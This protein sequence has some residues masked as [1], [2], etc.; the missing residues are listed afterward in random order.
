MNI[1]HNV[2]IVYKMLLYDLL[3][4][5]ADS[6]IKWRNPCEITHHEQTLPQIICHEGIQLKSNLI[7][8][9]V[10]CLGSGPCCEGCKYLDDNG[11]TVKCLGC[12]LGLCSKASDRHPKL[13]HFLIH[14][15]AITRNQ[16]RSLLGIRYS[17]EETYQNLKRRR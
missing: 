12:K 10:T 13:D 2:S 14:M 9:E 1:K 6:L 8:H 17:R 5:I 7:I 16:G 15:T 11:C 3:Y 4:F